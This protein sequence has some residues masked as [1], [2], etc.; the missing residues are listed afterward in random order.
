MILHYFETPNG[1][2]ACAVA[3]HLDAP[4]AYVRIDLAKGEHRAP[5]FLAVNPNGKI[6]ALEDGATKLWEASAIMVHLARKAESDLWPN[7]DR[8]VEA[9]RWLSWSHDH[10]SRHA[11]ALFFQTVIKPAV[12]MGN[13]DAAAVE[14]ATG[15]LK[16][17]GRVLDDHL[18]GRR[19]LL[20]D[21][22]TVADFEVAAF[23]PDTPAARAALEGFREVGRWQGRMN[24][25]PAWREPFPVA[26]A[27]AA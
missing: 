16:Q 19:F 10:F 27:A 8:Q 3:R 4:V 17:F 15:Y 6:P 1:R 5:A 9:I 22:P 7:D 14:E 26:A 20:G 21:T 13:P 12:G 18:A 25:L 24:E 2:K 23:L 11:G